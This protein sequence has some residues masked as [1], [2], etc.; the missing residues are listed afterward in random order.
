DELGKDTHKNYQV[1]TQFL[2]HEAFAIAKKVKELE[3]LML[4]TTKEL[5][6]E[7]IHAA[8]AVKKKLDKYE[9]D[10]KHL[11]WLEKETKDEEAKL[12]EF[13]AKENKIKK[14]ISELKKSKDL[15]RF[16]KVKEDQ[17]KKLEEL[18]KEKTKLFAHFSDLERPLKKYKRGSL[19]EDLINKYLVD[20]VEALKDDSEL[21]IAEVLGKL[22]NNIHT[23]DLKDKK[24]GKVIQTVD[25]LSKEFLQERKAELERLESEHKELKRQMSGNVIMMQLMEQEAFLD[26]NKTLMNMQQRKV[27]EAAE[28]IKHIQPERTQKDIQEML[29]DTVNVILDETD[30]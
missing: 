4:K 14:K 12:H 28:K 22:K 23:L 17:E 27:E 26:N 11:E 29:K 30:E 20:H 9:E 21:K 6:K 24:Q 1:L 15:E 25:K 2:E 8:Q 18:K 10:L 5:E 7:N 3:K 16:N 13:K 19:D